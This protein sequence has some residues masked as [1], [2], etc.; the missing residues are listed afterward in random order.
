MPAQDYIRLSE[1]L[2]KATFVRC[3][4]LYFTARMIK[5]DEEVAILRRVGELT[6]RV[7]GDVLAEIK[8][9]MTEKA[10]RRRSS[11]TR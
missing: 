2:P 8:P 7:I 10:G 4:D 9:G 3:K 6:D 1:R 11:A 5:T